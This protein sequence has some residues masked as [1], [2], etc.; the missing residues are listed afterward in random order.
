MPLA[1]AQSL[2]ESRQRKNKQTKKDKDLMHAVTDA[3]PTEGW[4][5]TRKEEGSSVGTSEAPIWAGAKWAS[6][7]LRSSPFP[8]PSSHAGCQLLTASIRAASK[9][10]Q[11]CSA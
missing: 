2:N 5:G 3:H 4:A 11:L 7:G 6:P 1:L 10:F 8:T 9:G